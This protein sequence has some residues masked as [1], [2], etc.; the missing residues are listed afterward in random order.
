MEKFNTKLGNV[1]CHTVNIG[2]L[3]Q[4][5]DAQFVDATGEKIKIPVEKV[6]L[7]LGILYNK[8]KQSFE[9]CE[10]KKLEIDLGSTTTANAIENLLKF[11]LELLPD[12]ETTKITA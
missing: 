10:G 8:I 12:G 6:P 11:L 5:I 7:L 9:E 4:Q 1:G 2:L 3:L